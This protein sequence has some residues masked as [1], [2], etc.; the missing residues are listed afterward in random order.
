MKHSEVNPG[1][2]WEAVTAEGDTRVFLI[3]D[4]D[5]KTECGS[6][7]EYR[8][9]ELTSS[10]AD[11]RQYHLSIRMTEKLP[12]QRICPRTW[13]ILTHYDQIWRRLN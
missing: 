1:D 11:V 4:V 6:W 3:L 7:D 10:S 9:V 5:L 2:V 12:S 8:Y 13:R